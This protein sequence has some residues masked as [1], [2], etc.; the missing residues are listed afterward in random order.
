MKRMLFPTASAAASATA[1]TFALLAGAALTLQSAPA[2][3]SDDLCNVPK[4]EWQP[5]ENLEAKLTADGWTVKK[6]KTEDGCYEVYAQTPDGKRVEA[7]FNPKTF[8]AV[9]TKE[10]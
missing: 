3:A 2:R 8:E 6:I 5:M 7:Y 1:L 10:D 9:K 4:A